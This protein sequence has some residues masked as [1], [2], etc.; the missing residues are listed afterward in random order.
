MENFDTEWSEPTY[1]RSVTYRLTEGSYRFNLLSYNYDGLTNNDIVG[2]EIIIRKPLWRMWWFF[3]IAF[4][5]TSFLVILVIRIRERAQKKVKQYLEDELQERTRE[6]VKQKEEIEMQNREIT[7]SI[8]YALRIQ[9][10]LLPPVK[11]LQEKFQGAFIFFRPRDIVSGDFFW[12]DQVSNNKII[13]VCADS[14]GHGVPGAFMSMIGSALIQEIVNR[15]EITRPSEILTTLDKEISSTL[16]Q[17]VGDSTTSDGM[18]MVVCEFD[19][20]T[21]LLRFA[22]ALR[23]VII[24]MD[25]EQYYIRGNKNSVGGEKL[26]NKYFD[27]QEYYLKKGDIVYLF[28]DGYPDQFGGPDG[29]KLKIVRLKRL[30]EDIK[31]HPIEEQH[32]LVEEYFDTWKGDQ[33][34]VDDVL[35]MG[36]MI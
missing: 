15:K 27:D 35:F 4:I 16:N 19:I 5:F 3:A 20:S 30:I 1:D 18:D 11:R 6:V 9:E 24:V 8:N 34:Q 7:D 31:D 23:P 29:K 10:G 2:F 25:G 13:M 21:R 26:A 32:K 33:E 22:S 17:D 28:S 12:F 14:T 36:F